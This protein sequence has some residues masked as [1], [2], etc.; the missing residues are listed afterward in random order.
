MS[1]LELEK[2][3][4]YDIHFVRYEDLIDDPVATVT[5][6]ARWAG[7]PAGPTAVEWAVAQSEFSTMRKMEADDG[8]KLFDREYVAG[9]PTTTN[10]TVLRQT[11]A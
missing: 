11:N 4:T 9:R 5:K 1:Y 10:K 3:E 8:L 6:L 2:D 7:L